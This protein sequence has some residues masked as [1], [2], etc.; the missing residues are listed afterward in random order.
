MKKSAKLLSLLLSLAM[1]FSLSTAVLA[2]DS[3]VTLGT[4]ARN[5]VTLAFGTPGSAQ[6]GLAPA[7][8]DAQKAVGEAGSFQ[9]LPIAGTGNTIMNP[10]M[11]C[12][13]AE[14]SVQ[15]SKDGIIGDLSFSLDA[16][17][18]SKYTGATCLQFNYTA[19][20]EGSVDVT[21]TYYYNFNQTGV[22]GGTTWYKETAAFTVNVVGDPDPAAKPAQPTKSDIERFRNYVNSTSSSKGA[23]YMWCDDYDHHAWFDYITDVD[24][25][26]TLGEVTANDGS[27]LSKATYP[28]VCVMTLDAAKYLGAYNDLLGDEYGTHYLKDGQSETETATWY[29]NAE[30]SKWRHFPSSEAPVY[31][32]ITHAAPAAAEY[33]VTYTDGVNGAA[34][35]DQTYTVGNGEAT[36]AFVGTPS[37][38]GYVFLGW[39]PEVAKTVTANATYTARWEEALTNVTVKS[40][41][42]EGKLLFLKDTFTVTAA[43]NTSADITLSITNNAGKELLGDVFKVA[44][45]QVSEDGRTTVYTIET[46]RISA[47]YQRLNITATA[48]KGTQEPVTSKVPA[49]GVN[50]RNRIHV[51]VTSKV[52][53]EAVTD[54]AVQLM[55]Q[56][57]KWNKCPSLKYDAAKSEYV[58]RNSWDLCNQPFTA[59]N[60]TV[61]GKT[62]TVDKTSDGRDLK[63]VITAG[64]EEIYVNYVIV[65]PITVTINVDGKSAAAYTFEGSDGEKLDYS[66]LFWAVMDELKKA[67]TVPA[68]VTTT[69]GDGADSAEFGKCTS[70][71]VNIT[72][73]GSGITVSGDDFPWDRGESITVRGDDFVWG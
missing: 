70:V 66:K 39:E 6:S 32:G 29:Y 7:Y 28:W 31:I 67:G 21:L 42:K 60:I 16:W 53:G 37:R 23:V 5:Q 56:Y 58:M 30:L 2:A 13:P 8:D 45:T 57:P 34:F 46:A 12:V 41:I 19:L 15:L 64:T 9:R 47:D 18:G 22:I 43:A 25:A 4:A 65:D 27:V 62:Y 61:N 36:P 35:A 20:A 33:T 3:E 59:V 11:Y 26:Y 72:T 51:T 73:I 71:T 48:K 17:D 55:H 50:L 44:D 14:G 38:E 1:V 52:S 68:T 63:S 10:R 69:Y 24:D 54:A 49:F 40:G